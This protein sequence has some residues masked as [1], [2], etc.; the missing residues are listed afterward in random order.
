MR[1]CL[2]RHPKPDVVSGTCYGRTDVPILTSW[3]EE[4][5]RLSALLRQCLPNASYFHSPLSRARLLGEMLDE[6]SAPIAELQELDFGN[7][8][9]RLWQDIP[10]PEIRSWSAE[11]A[12][13]APYQGESLQDL[14][15]RVMP[16][17]KSMAEGD[18]DC[19]LVTHSGVIKV[20]VSE[21]C[22]WPLEKCSPI[23][24]DFLSYTLLTINGEFVTLDCLGS[25]A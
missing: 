14:K 19:V 21:L 5:S 17:I 6:H 4:A 22:C 15:S 8:E 9:G 16:L 1:L 18:R 2:V 23:N 25:R 24:P 10:E 11:L 20:I 13:A 7:W 3:Q 12:T